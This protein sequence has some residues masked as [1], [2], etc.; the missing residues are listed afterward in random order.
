MA[1]GLGTREV[2]DAVCVLDGGVSRVE[3]VTSGDSTWDLGTEK[4]NE[5]D[6]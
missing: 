6:T 3:K 2:D 1:A 5:E 4:T